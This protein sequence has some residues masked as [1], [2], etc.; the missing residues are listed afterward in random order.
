MAWNK[1]LQ[2]VSLANNMIYVQKP[3]KIKTGFQYW[4]AGGCCTI[5]ILWP[6]KNC[7]NVTVVRSAF[8][9]GG[10]EEF[11]TA[12]M[13]WVSPTLLMLRC[14]A[15]KMDCGCW[16]LLLLHINPSF[17]CSFPEFST[18]LS[19]FHLQG[20][21][22]L[23]TFLRALRRSRW[24]YWVSRLKKKNGWEWFAVVDFF[25]II[26][27]VWSICFSECAGWILQ[28]ILYGILMLLPSF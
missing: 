12:D 11:T 5:P 8:N 10:W 3:V 18:H 20:S 19:I 17:L 27:R 21:L 9:F 4:E 15:Q 26:K 7:R 13:I 28:K 6:L 14:S 23:I 22:I 1:I 24:I 25:P 2:N 16:R